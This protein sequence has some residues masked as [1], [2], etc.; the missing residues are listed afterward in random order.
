VATRP[1]DVIVPVYNA[2]DAV[3]RCLQSALAN[4]TG[5]EVRLVLADD[6]SPDPRIPPLLA[7]FAARDP[8]VV[9]V[10]RPHNL[11]FVR[12]CNQAMREAP[13]DVVLLNSDTEVPPGWLERLRALAQSSPR[14]GSV[15]PLSNNATICS[16]PRW[17]RPN[18]FPPAVGTPLLDEVARAA[19]TGEWIELPTSVG[20]CVYFR[21]E[22]LD[23]CGYFDDS[24]FGTGYGEENDLACRMRDRG[25]LNLLCD[26]LFVWHEGGASFEES[27]TGDL[28]GNLERITR[29]WPRYHDVIRGFIE[30]NPLWGVQGRFGLELLRR[31]KSSRRRVL[32]LVHNRLWSGFIGGTELHLADLIEALGDRIDPVVLSFGPQARGTLQ[33]RPEGGGLLE[34]PFEPATA[35]DPYPW[36]GRL[37]D[38]GIDLLHVQ[39]PM[40]TPLPV[41]G[42]LLESAH[43]R[44]IPIA[45]T[46]HDYFA[47]CPGAQLL[48]AASGTPCTSLRGGPACPGCE[49]QAHRLAA[50]S[51][52]VWRETYRGL[53]G[54]ADALFT[55]S[56]AARD[57]LVAEMP[58]LRDRLAVLPHGIPGAAQLPPPGRAGRRVAVLGYGGR[59]KGDTVL[60]QVMD[61]LEP[62]EVTWHLFGR[63]RLDRKPRRNVVLHGTYRREDLGTLLEQATVDLV[64]LLSPWA[65]TYSYTLSEAWRLGLPVIGSDL[66]AIGE[67]IR[68]LGGGVTVDPWDPEAV[69]A[70]LERLLGDPP[71]LAAL[72]REAAAIGA[73]LP[74][75]D[76]MAGSYHASYGV[77]AP[78]ARP[79]APEPFAA[80]PDPVEMEGWLGSFRSPLRA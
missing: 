1:V 14:V 15:T 66:G 71:A 76:D 27:G 7:S 60:G 50:C 8:R 20:F 26:T 12:N 21:R 49:E 51:L 16:V 29:A 41:L 63:R 59:H 58:E 13:G 36:L 39:H 75:L 30:R 69:A 11:G 4:T 34:F 62:R 24:L 28:A 35:P 5:P 65:E 33:W 47:L 22:A 78:L 57:I 18:R 38:T 61:A 45:W 64:L 40:R 55:P 10:R 72:R 74:T 19:G 48:D 68:G 43:R 77:L 6:A 9:V 25:Y 32:Y 70:A 54:R 79:A 52:P 31:T 42:A 46:L 37:L 44:N 80:A 2:H 17:L 3:A 53:V 73:T 67:R 23:A 56:A